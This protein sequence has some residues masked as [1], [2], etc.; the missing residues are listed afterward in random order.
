MGFSGQE[1]W[2]GLPFPLPADLPNPEIEPGSPVLQAASLLSEPPR[3]LFLP[4]TSIAGWKVPTEVTPLGSCSYLWVLSAQSWLTLCDQPGSSVHG[5]F[6]ARTLEWVTISYFRKSS[7]PKESNPHL[8]CLLH[9]QVL[10]TT[11]ATWEAQ[12]HISREC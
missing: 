3:K 7:Q 2:S 5:I 12:V 4:C 6:Q 9:W 11:R 8:L 1:Y 10:L